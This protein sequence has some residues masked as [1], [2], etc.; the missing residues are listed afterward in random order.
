M[1]RLARE[2]IALQQRLST[3]KK[4]MLGK[5]EHLTWTAPEEVD[6]E[7]DTDSATS[8][9]YIDGRKAVRKPNSPSEA[10]LP[11]KNDSEQEMSNESQHPLSLTINSHRGASN[12]S[13][14][15]IIYHDIFL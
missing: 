9:D 13:Q 12:I 1:E 6:M 8:V 3:L 2:K 4:D 10:T 7:M 14:T 5:Y 15:L 11:P